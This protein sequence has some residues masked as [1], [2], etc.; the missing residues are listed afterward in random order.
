MCCRTGQHGLSSDSCIRK[1]LTVEITDGL[2]IR[3]R[4]DNRGTALSGFT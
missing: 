1:P 3:V 4:N 2:M